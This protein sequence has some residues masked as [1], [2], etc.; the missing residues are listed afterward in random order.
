M[1][2]LTRHFKYAGH[3]W[4]RNYE[5]IF[6]SDAGAKLALLSFPTG[7]S[8]CKTVRMR[9]LTEKIGLKRRRMIV[10]YMIF[11]LG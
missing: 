10:S 8:E 5:T 2:A 7:P 4:V 3:T 11:A 6:F 9:Q 1:F